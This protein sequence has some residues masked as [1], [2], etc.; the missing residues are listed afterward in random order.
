MSAL[1]DRVTELV[2]RQREQQTDADRQALQLAYL[3][4][5]EPFEAEFSQVACD[6]PDK[7]AHDCDYPDWTPGGAR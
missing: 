3:H 4:Q 7:C 2:A 1:R 5:P 6:H